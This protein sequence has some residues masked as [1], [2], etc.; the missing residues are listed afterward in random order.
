M[1]V[2]FLYETYK[3]YVK[4][5]NLFPCSFIR[6]ER[7]IPSLF[8]TE[9]PVRERGWICFLDIWTYLFQFNKRYT[10][11]HSFFGL[12]HFVFFGKT[13]F[14]WNLA[15]GVKLFFWGGGQNLLFGQN[16]F[17]RFWQNYIFFGETELVCFCQLAKPSLFF[18]AQLFLRFWWNYCFF[19]N[20]FC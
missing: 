2:R 9:L 10:F 20:F 15:G 7:I 14:L 11:R 3:L 17:W 8:W 12:E 6:G 5:I 18:L 13:F 1:N 4:C 19:G 16:F